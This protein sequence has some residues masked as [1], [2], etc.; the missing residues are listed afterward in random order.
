MK[1]GLVSPE[2][3]I[4][5]FSN[6]LSRLKQKPEGCKDK[7][8]SKA[9]VEE[10]KKICSSVDGKK[11]HSNR[12]KV[13]IWWPSDLHALPSLGQKVRVN[14]FDQM[15]DERIALLTIDSW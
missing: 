12:A 10:V 2:D 7:V 3:K 8:S 1:S 5:T 14:W 9:S 6:L 4:Y 15:P 13:M 11:K